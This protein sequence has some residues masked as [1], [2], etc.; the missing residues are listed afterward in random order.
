MFSKGFKKYVCDGDQIS[1]HLSNGL[2]IVATI[3]Y[4][5]GVT[6][7]DF[8]CY[9]PD[10]I[11]RWKDNQWWFGWLEVRVFLDNVELARASLSGIDCNFIDNNEYLLECS[12]E[13]LQECLTHCP[14]RARSI[15]KRFAKYL[16]ESK[17]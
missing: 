4:D 15:V 6:P 8:E 13:L 10:D 3:R 9:S 14:T 11:R 17:K 12:N 1:D 16:K 7:N 2:Q 5:E